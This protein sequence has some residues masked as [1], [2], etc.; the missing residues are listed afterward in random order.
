MLNL[1]NKKMKKY[2]TL[3]LLIAV[4]FHSISQNII[5]QSNTTFNTAGNISLTL[6]D[7]GISSASIT[8]LSGSNL[9]L[10][11]SNNIT[12][13]TNGNFA[14]Q[15]LYI[16][17]KSATVFLGSTVNINT[18][19]NMIQ[20]LLDLNN[21]NIILSPAAI[22]NGETETTRIT[23]PNGGEIII[24]INLNAPNAINPGNLGAVITSV[25]DLGNVIIRRGHRTQ[26]GVG[27]SNSINRYYDIQPANNT[28]LNATLRFNY[29][30]AE[31]NQQDE[32]AITMFR[33]DD[34]GVNWINQTLTS[35][36]AVMNYLEKTGITTFS[37]W[38]L[39]STNEGPL[40]VLGLQFNAKRISNSKVQL[41]WKTQQEINNAGFY[42]ERK[43]ETDN[44]FTQIGFANSLAPGG[45]SNMPR[46]YTKIDIN[47]SS[48]DT[49]YRLK[50]M[51]IDGHFVYSNIQLVKGEVGNTIAL[52]TWPVPAP[53]YFN[54][55]VQGINKNDVMQVIDVNGKLI[56]QIQVI[57]NTLQ[58]VNNLRP[59]IYFLRLANTRG[60]QQKIIVQ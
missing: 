38:T 26:S 7:F 2:I 48:R 54:V 21:K 27:L 19:V 50:Q 20:G 60:V 16:D 55:I 56:Q 41:D 29:F 12:L 35:R 58:K 28:N 42:I 33:S 44:D 1:T 31:L 25:A 22:I 46:E 49:Y 36:D 52:R 9:Y 59:G 17:K 15:N 24:G 47:F 32:N 34:G 6:V 14:L 3:S 18:G 57:D 30:D 43:S 39:S 53:G 40:P 11:G 37:K 8:D 51:D 23:G 10:K 13:A 4:S 45:N 5:V